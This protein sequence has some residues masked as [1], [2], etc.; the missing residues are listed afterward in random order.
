MFLTAVFIGQLSH[1]EEHDHEEPH[2]PDE[3]V[4]AAEPTGPTI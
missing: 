1:H 4:F 3:P 2:M